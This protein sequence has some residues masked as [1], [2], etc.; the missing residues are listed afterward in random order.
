MNET[1]LAEALRGIEEGSFDLG[2]FLQVSLTLA[3]TLTL[4]LAH[5]RL[6]AYM[7]YVPCLQERRGVR[8]P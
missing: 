5:R 4:T 3:L 8:R 1:E 7:L 2:D 6:H